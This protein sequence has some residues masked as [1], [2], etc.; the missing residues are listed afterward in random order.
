MATNKINH[1]LEA[2]DGADHH[3][4]DILGSF[5]GCTVEASDGVIVLKIA[6]SDSRL[7]FVA[8]EAEIIARML[9][10]EAPAI[11]DVFSRAI[12][13]VR[14]SITERRDTFDSLEW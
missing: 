4:A 6:G 10:V 7:L 2:D 5:N 12:S 14:K 11:A 1:K 9:K 13:R 8:R 3:R